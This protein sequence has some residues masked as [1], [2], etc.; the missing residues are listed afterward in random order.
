MGKTAPTSSTP[1]GVSVQEL[2]D[3]LRPEAPPET[4]LQGLKQLSEALTNQETGEAVGVAF[5]NSGA[6][7]NLLSHLV[8]SASCARTTAA[9]ISPSDIEDVRQEW[10][11]PECGFC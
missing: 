8:T 2:A 4:I 9:G 10:T 5:I 6:M 11:R 3:D 7:A 1:K